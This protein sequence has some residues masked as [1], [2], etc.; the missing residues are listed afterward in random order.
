MCEDEAIFPG[1]GT[2]Y[3]SRQFEHVAASVPLSIIGVP[4][5]SSLSGS[6]VH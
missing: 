1:P 6:R 5:S 3:T 2:G 4:F